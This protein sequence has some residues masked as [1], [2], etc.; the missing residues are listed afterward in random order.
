MTRLRIVG[1]ILIMFAAAMCLP[2]VLTRRSADLAQAYRL[3]WQRLRAS[4][5]SSL[6]YRKQNEQVRLNDARIPVVFFGASITGG[7]RL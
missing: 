5:A 1:S 7:F 4:P 3:R 6:R 2:Y